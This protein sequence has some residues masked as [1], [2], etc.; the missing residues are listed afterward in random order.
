MHSAQLPALPTYWHQGTTRA[1]QTKRYASAEATERREFWDLRS[2]RIAP[3][4]VSADTSFKPASL[5]SS[6]GRA[7]QE[8]AR[9][10]RLRKASEVFAFAAR[11][12]NQGVTP[13]ITTYEHLLEACK[14]ASLQQEAWTVFEDML[15]V[16][17]L[18]T[19][20]IF[21]SLMQVSAATPYCV[22]SETH[23]EAGYAL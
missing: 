13:D 15:A 19:R 1:L 10:V 14:E 3:Y 4:A 11:M 18:P 22:S 6:L 2:P 16:G 7:N 5:A 20:S 12:K 8:L 21:H 23:H 17:I 9:L